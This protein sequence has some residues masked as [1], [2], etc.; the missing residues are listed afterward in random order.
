MVVLP[1][2]IFCRRLSGRSSFKASDIMKDNATLSEDVSTL[3][4]SVIAFSRIQLSSGNAALTQ[5]GPETR[6]ELPTS[7]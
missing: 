6:P 3:R 1:L 7:A 2:D 5:S 4:R